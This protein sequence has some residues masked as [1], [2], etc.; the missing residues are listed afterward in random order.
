MVTRVKNLFC[1]ITQKTGSSLAK[2]ISFK[3]KNADYTKSLLC[4]RHQ[5]FGCLDNIFMKMLLGLQI[6]C[7]SVYKYK[8]HSQQAIPK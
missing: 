5:F 2:G 4:F 1:F 3:L 7:C 6:V 8:Y